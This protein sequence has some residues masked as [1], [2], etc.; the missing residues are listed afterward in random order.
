MRRADGSPGMMDGPGAGKGETKEIRAIF[1][2]PP[3]LLARKKSDA[4]A[5]RSVP[6]K[7]KP[8]PGE[9]LMLRTTTNEKKK[10]RKKKK[11][12]KKKK[13]AAPHSNAN[14]IVHQNVFLRPITS[15]KAP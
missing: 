2:F 13:G 14:Q 8:E 10:K 9:D 4:A 12:E 1:F 15:T 7:G 5:N 3:D 6:T 11:K